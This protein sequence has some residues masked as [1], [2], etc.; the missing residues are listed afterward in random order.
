MWLLPLLVWAPVMIIACE[1]GPGPI[2]TS[3][4]LAHWAKH[5]CR[6]SD[7]DRA[8]MDRQVFCRLSPSDGIK[9]TVACAR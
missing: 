3:G 6:M 8:S 9:V 1:K 7:E 4:R 2:D 5:D